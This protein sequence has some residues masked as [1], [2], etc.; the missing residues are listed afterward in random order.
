[1]GEC[2]YLMNFKSGKNSLDVFKFECVWLFVVISGNVLGYIWECR[3]G[4]D[5]K[6]EVKMRLMF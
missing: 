1:M 2:K 3:I 6:W 5:F 4:F